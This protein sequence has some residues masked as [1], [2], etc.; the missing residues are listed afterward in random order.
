MT[1]EDY[2]EVKGLVVG[3][4]FIMD[5]YHQVSP[6]TRKC[7]PGLQVFEVTGITGGALSLRPVSVAPDATMKRLRQLPFNAR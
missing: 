1:D 7:L 3:Q 2:I 6:Q 4:R 5:G